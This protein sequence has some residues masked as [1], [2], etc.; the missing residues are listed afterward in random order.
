MERT[1]GKRNLLIEKRK[2][3]WLTE[4][5]DE[6]NAEWKEDLEKNSKLLNSM[7]PPGVASGIETCLKLQAKYQSSWGKDI[8]GPLIN[9]IRPTESVYRKPL[10]TVAGSSLFHVLV[11]DETVARKCMDT[12]IKERSGRVTFM[13]ISRLNRDEPRYPSQP[14]DSTDDNSSFIPIVN[15]IQTANRRH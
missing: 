12:L 8:Y 6:R 13:P 3:L 15:C 10:E 1:R 11:R 7:M 14:S 4:S 2:T 5:F 9:L